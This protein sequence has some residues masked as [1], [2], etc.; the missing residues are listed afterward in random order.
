MLPLIIENPALLVADKLLFPP[1]V[2]AKDCPTLKS[3]ERLVSD[4]VGGAS[5]AI[6]TVVFR[7][8]GLVPAAPFAVALTLNVPA[9]VGVPESTSVDVPEANALRPGAL[10]LG[11]VIDVALEAVLLAL[12]AV[13]AFPDGNAA[14]LFHE[15]LVGAAIVMERD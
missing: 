1:L 3:L 9:D 8:V 12:Y 5:G 11:D 2:V 7:V 13:P 14:V 10:V 6:V 15:G 4:H